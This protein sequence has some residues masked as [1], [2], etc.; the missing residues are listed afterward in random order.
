MPALLREVLI[1]EL[2]RRNP[3]LLIALDGV[4]DVDEATE[5]GVGISDERRLGAAGDRA[6]RSSIS[7]KEARP[8]SGR[9]R[10]EAEMP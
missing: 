7:V 8:A 3:G 2:D 6:P 1:L 9:P 10:C 5:T 4:A